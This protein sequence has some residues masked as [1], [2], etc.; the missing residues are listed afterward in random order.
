LGQEGEFKFWVMVR[1]FLAAK[2][3]DT[4]IHRGYTEKHGEF[5]G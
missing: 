5:Y 3:H 4:E 2:E 1:S